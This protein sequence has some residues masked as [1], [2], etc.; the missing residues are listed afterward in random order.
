MNN[1]ELMKIE[2]QPKRWGDSPI[3]SPRTMQ[4]FRKHTNGCIAG[5]AIALAFW[6]A[7]AMTGNHALNALNKTPLMKTAVSTIAAAED[8]LMPKQM[9]RL[10]KQYDRFTH[11]EAVSKGIT[12]ADWNSFIDYMAEIV[13]RT[14]KPFVR[15]KEPEKESMMEKYN[16]MSELY[17]V[18]QA[19]AFV[20]EKMREKYIMHFGDEGYDLKAVPGQRTEVTGGQH[21]NF[22][23]ADW[24]FFIDVYSGV[25]EV[26]PASLEDSDKIWTMFD[27][28]TEGLAPAH[29]KIKIEEK[30]KQGLQINE[31]FTQKTRLVNRMKANRAERIEKRTIQ[32]TGGG[33]RLD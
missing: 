21:F 30:V 15:F 26:L 2:E 28:Y 7:D 29:V 23:K 8:T 4:S 5:L 14:A 11:S 10:E 33:G 3:V 1:D 13:I 31:Q 24:E 22:T 9:P 6:G 17:M 20:E 27:L 25:V 16:L 32:R 12:D 18:G 19:P